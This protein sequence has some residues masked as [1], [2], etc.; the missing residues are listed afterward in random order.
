MNNIFHNYLD[1]YASAFLDDI[2]IYLEMLKEHTQHVHEVLKQLAEAGLYLRR[3]K[4]LFYRTEVRHN[5]VSGHSADRPRKSE[6]N[7]RLADTKKS[8]EGTG[9]SWA[10]ELL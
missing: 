7:Y 1:Q 10:D 8:Q 3:K 4:Y 6:G 9:L 2:I 5:P